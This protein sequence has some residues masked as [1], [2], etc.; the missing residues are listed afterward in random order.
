MHYSFDMFVTVFVIISQ[1][2]TATDQLLKRKYV[3]RRWVFLAAALKLY[4]DAVTNSHKKGI[5]LDTCR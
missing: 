5:V 1:K 3:V 4:L 2:I